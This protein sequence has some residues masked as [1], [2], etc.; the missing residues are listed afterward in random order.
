MTRHNLD[1]HL[2]W[3]ISTKASLPPDVSLP[4]ATVSFGPISAT[5]LEDIEDIPD[6]AF[7]DDLSE[8]T[9]EA[10]EAQEIEVRPTTERQPGM[11]RLRAAPGSA[12]KPRL[13]SVD[14][15]SQ[16]DGNSTNPARPISKWKQTVQSALKA[17]SVPQTPTKNEWEMPDSGSDV[18]IMDLTEGMSRLKSPSIDRIVKTGTSRK[19]KSEEY[20]ADLD[21]CPRHGSPVSSKVQRTAKG[22][23]PSGVRP[24]VQ[25]PTSSEYSTIDEVLDEAPT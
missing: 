4:P 10:P 13:L 21:D 3:L 1:V 22:P 11:A 7:D 23:T 6:G 5:P 9:T 8:A 15:G 2:R 24:K 19:R 17:E 20:R 25:P 12:A 16:I 14:A 18:E